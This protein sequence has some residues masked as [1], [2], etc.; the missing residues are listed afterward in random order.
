MEHQKKKVHRRC[1]HSLCDFFVMRLIG[2]CTSCENV[3]CRIHRHPTSHQCTKLAFIRD[4]ERKNLENKLMTE[5]ES[6]KK[7]KIMM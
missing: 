3:Y 7:A 2:Q 6:S 5:S 4:K 1:D